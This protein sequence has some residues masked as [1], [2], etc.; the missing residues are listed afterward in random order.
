GGID[1]DRGGRVRRLHDRAEGQ[2]GLLGQG[3][4]LNDGGRAAG[5]RARRS[6]GESGGD[7]GRHH[8]KTGGDF[9]DE[10]HVGLQIW[11]SNSKKKLQNLLAD[12]TGVHADAT[13]K[14]L[15]IVLPTL[16]GV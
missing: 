7:Q 9:D 6:L 3:D 16:A 15:F 5:D 12:R 2:V 11:G 8:G 1:G 10:F 4:R 13:L 14:G